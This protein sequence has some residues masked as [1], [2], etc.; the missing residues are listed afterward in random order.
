MCI[1]FHVDYVIGTIRSEVIRPATKDSRS[2]AR[3]PTKLWLLQPLYKI[4]RT[5]NTLRGPSRDVQVQ[6]PYRQQQIWRAT[7]RLDRERSHL[8]GATLLVCDGMWSGCGSAGSYSC[9]QC[10]QH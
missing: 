4:I 3:A 5:Q 2:K 8:H 1:L 7:S 9:T 10:N 6:S